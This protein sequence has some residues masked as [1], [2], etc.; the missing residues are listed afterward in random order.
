M[1][2]PS[3]SVQKLPGSFPAYYT[4]NCGTAL[5]MCTRVSGSTALKIVGGND[6]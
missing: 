3:A 2:W 1:L 5:V 6:Q 4:F